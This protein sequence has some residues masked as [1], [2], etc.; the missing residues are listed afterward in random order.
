MSKSKIFYAKV[1]GLRPGTP[2]EEVIGYLQ[3]ARCGNGKVTELTWIGD[4]MTAAIVGIEGVS[5]KSKYLL[6]CF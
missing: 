3:T 2:K 6:G 1:W 5:K 4:T